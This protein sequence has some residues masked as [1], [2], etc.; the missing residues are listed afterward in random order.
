MNDD[1]EGETKKRKLD[2]WFIFFSFFFLGHIRETNR[3]P[4]DLLIFSLSL[5]H[6]LS[7]SSCAWNEVND[8]AMKLKMKN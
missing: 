4:T 7:S 1:G 3:F 5:F 8:A 2:L 6:P